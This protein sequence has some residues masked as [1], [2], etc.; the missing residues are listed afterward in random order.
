MSSKS[1]YLPSYRLPTNKNADTSKWPEI[2]V[3]NQNLT[4]TAVVIIGGGISGMCAAIDLL[5]NRNIKNFVILEKSGGFGGTWRDNKFPGCCCDVFSV[6]YSY[7]FAQNPQWSRRYP[8]QEEILEYL[9]D[10]AQKY[11][12]YKYA[13]F[14]TIVEAAA[15]NDK[16]FK[17]EISVTIGGG[18]ESEFSSSYKITSDFL[19]TGTGQ[20]NKPKG[21]D[22]PG[23]Q[24][25]QGKIMHSARWDWS[26]DMSGKRIAIIGTGATTAQIAPEVA[27]VASQLTICQRTP[28]WVIP[29]HDSEIPQWKR[30]IYTYLP[31]ARWRGRAEAMDFRESFHSAVTKSDSPYADLMR[32]MNHN[33]IRQQLPDRPDLWGK[34]SPNYHPGCKRTVISDDYYPTL[35]RKNVKLETDKIERFTDDGIKFVGHS[36]A[37]KFD[38]IVLA[39]GFDTFS[40]LSPMEITGRNGRPLKEIWANASHA[41]KGVTVPDLPNFGMLYGPNTNLSHNSLI[42]VIE[43]QTKYISVLIDQVLK[44]R[45][46]GQS[47]ALCPSEEQTL[48]Y[49]SSLQMALQKTSFS[50]PNC[51]S[52][53]KRDDGIITNNWAG[54]AIDYQKNLT[55]V[56]WADYIAFGTAS[57]E[58]D[59]LS[60]NHC[61]TRIHRVVEETSLSRTALGVFAV[62]AI[63]LFVHGILLSI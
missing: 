36:S 43:A 39:T 5:V 59:A 10:V 16:T 22:V 12:L 26:Y 60:R 57:H 40:F 58:I 15:W 21:I 47:L 25:F 34:L 48:N 7:S 31:P 20:L 61:V 18:K 32:S 63:G 24:D 35:A 13:R 8:G 42:L 28:A 29:R 30:W 3:S 54:T 1:G 37:D 6:L 49:F 62:G 50:D 38:L 19:V 4:N 41:Y 11:G 51:N 14:H 44:A 53:W 27:K 46:E 17:W 45:R 9:T 23:Y 55:T 56:E 2:P 33:L 52:W